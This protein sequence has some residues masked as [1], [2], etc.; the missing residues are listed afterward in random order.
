[1]VTIGK[2]HWILKVKLRPVI[3]CEVRW[4]RIALDTVGLVNV[5]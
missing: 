3:D 2:S 5:R 1:M 4:A